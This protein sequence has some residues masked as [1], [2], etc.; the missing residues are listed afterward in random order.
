VAPPYGHNVT[1]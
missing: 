1:D